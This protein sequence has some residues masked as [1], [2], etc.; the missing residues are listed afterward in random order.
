MKVRF[1]WRRRDR[2]LS[3]RGTG[4]RR[5]RRDTDRQRSTP[6]SPP[7]ARR[8]RAQRRAGTSPLTRPRPTTSGADA[9]VAFIGLKPY[10]L[11]ELAPRLGE[12]LGAGTAVIP[13]QKE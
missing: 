4:P 10:S 12:A 5:K 13:A 3:R 6:E 8:P 7:G 1:R 9:D 2:R 11:P